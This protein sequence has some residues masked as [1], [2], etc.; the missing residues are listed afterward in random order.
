[1]L[2]SLTISS[3]LKKGF[4]MIR[5]KCDVA[6]CGQEL[7]EYGAILLGPCRD[8]KAKKQHVCL[9][10]YNLFLVQP[11]FIT[12]SEWKKYDAL[13]LGPPKGNVVDMHFINVSHYH[14]MQRQYF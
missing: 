3:T 4:R 6:S 9:P 8:R 5:P 11:H 10:C 13:M 12:E 14:V 7:G 1:M 2:E